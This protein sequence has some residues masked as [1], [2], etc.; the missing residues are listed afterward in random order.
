M[1]LVRSLARY[2]RSRPAVALARGRGTSKLHELCSRL[3]TTCSS[4]ALDI[5]RLVASAT[6]VT[7]DKI[8]DRLPPTCGECS[9]GPLLR[10]HEKRVIFENR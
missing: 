10:S 5:D 8:K 3:D 4:N 9:P 2:C 6:P 7:V 1:G